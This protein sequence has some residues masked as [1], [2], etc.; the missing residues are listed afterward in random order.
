MHAPVA[1][2]KK[3]KM[4]KKKK[5]RVESSR[6]PL[7]RKSDTGC[8]MTNISEPG[9]TLSLSNTTPLPNKTKRKGEKTHQ[10]F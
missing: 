2:R 8:R 1:A 10:K 9:S 6:N 3:K 5:S 4:K 7:R